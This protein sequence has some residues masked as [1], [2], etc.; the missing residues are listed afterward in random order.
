V[1]SEGL[2]LIRYQVAPEQVRSCD[3][4]RADKEY[5]DL[6]QN[7]LLPS[8]PTLAMTSALAFWLGSFVQSRYGI[9]GRGGHRAAWFQGE[10]LSGL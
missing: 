3:Y 10:L 1:L 6:L 5:Q 7:A 4:Q 8:A 2:Q 9:L